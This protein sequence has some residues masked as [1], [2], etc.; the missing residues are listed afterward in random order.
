MIS[1]RPLLPL[2]IAAGILLAG[3]GLQGTLIA[4][5]GQEEGFSTGLIGVIGAAYF[6]GFFLGCMTITQMLRSVGHIRCFAALAAMAASGT[7]ALV[8]FID[9]VAWIVLRFLIGFCFAGLFTVMESWINSSVGNATR[10][11]ATSVYR[12]IDLVGTTLSQ[13]MI[14]LFG[15][16]GFTIFGVMAIMITLSLVPVSLGDRSNPSPPKE[17][18]LDLKSVWL[19]SPLACIGSA[20]A[21][22]A[23]SA[24][25]LVGPL[26]AQSI[27]L[28][29]SQIATFISLGVIGGVVLQ[30]PLGS[31]SDR[32]DRRK[33]L[34][35]T[36]AAA[37][38]AALAIALMTQSGAL[39]HFVLIFIF[40][41]F[42]M[43]IYSL[44]AA[45]GNDNAGEG[46]YVKVAAALMFFYA[47]GA[48]IGPLTSSLLLTQFG[49]PALFYYLAGVYAF[50][51]AVTLYRM[52]VR[53]APPPE[54]R[55]RFTALIRTSPFF[56]R[57][58][59]RP[60]D[61]DSG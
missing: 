55:G 21:G 2:L 35:L 20:V 60:R 15:T 27:G 32:W 7:L 52:R 28:S 1:I 18:K 44:A 14:P 13:F 46:G 30:Y 12:V 40:S 45:H 39:S 31:L 22:L 36:S 17:L 47:I 48:V 56:A 50:F 58:A 23:N 53:S 16:N 6:A 19:I 49:N 33:V 38:L 42:A 34:V 10:G 57:L 61:K 9:P 8:L 29:V 43:P 11:R 41:A 59:H 54:E 3:N 25:R 4:L 26:Y 5:R 24:F 37:M 51:I